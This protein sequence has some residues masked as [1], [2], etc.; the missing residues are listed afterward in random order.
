MFGSRYSLGLWNFCYAFNVPT[1]DE[2]LFEEKDNRFFLN[3]SRTKNG[4]LV[5]LG[6]HSKT[7]SEVWLV[8]AHTSS[9]PT[10][11]HTHSRSKIQLL[12]SRNSKI[13]YYVEHV[14]SDIPGKLFKR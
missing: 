11:I 6:S 12:C 13:K 7:S 14:S 4:H 8:D 2:L 3:I 9:Q 5:L 10:E 1:E